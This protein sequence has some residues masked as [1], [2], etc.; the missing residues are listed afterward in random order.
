MK[1]FMSFLYSGL[2]ILAGC[3]TTKTTSFRHALDVSKAKELPPGR[4]VIIQTA[5]SEKE[6]SINVMVPR[7]KN[8]IYQVVDENQKEYA[9]QKLQT[10]QKAEV[11]YKIDQLYIPNLSLHHKYTLNVIDDFRGNKT[12]VDQRSFQTLDLNQ[13]QVRF[14]TISCMADDY[15]FNEVIDPMW[16]RLRLEKPEFVILNGDVVYVDSFDF[17]ERK[18]ATDLDLW[19]RYIDAFRRIPIYHWLELKPIFATWDDHDFGTNDGDREFVSKQEALRVFR[20]F[21]GGKPIEGH[22]ELGPHGVS[23]QITAF[24]QRFFLMDDRTYRQPNKNQKELESFGHWG[25]EQ[26]EWLLANIKKDSSPAWL[27]NGNQLFNGKGLDFK[28]A[29]E[30]N[31][32]KHFQKL[33]EDLGKIEAPVVF[34]SGDIHFSEIMRIPKERLGYETYEISS[35][36]MHSFTGEGWENPMRIHGMFTNEFNFVMIESKV[37]KNELSLNVKSLGLARNPYFQSKLKIHK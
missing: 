30:A 15:R 14:A 35:S 31:H 19:Q 23:S 29:F 17:V 33:I 18:K 6:T 2:L 5:T 12:L 25:Q 28:E 21:F 24:G 10:V 22:F 4:H 34:S 36:S 26:H 37:E 9:V 20:G 1:I 11:L 3:A 8:Y 27:F 16:E 32:P 13:K 7:L